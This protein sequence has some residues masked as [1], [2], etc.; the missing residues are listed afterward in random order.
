[1]SRKA[2]ASA[3]IDAADPEAG[4]SALLAEVRAC[5]LCAAELPLGPRPVLRAH[6]AARLL[7]VGQ[8]P[9]T[10]VHESGIP[11]ND[12]SGRRLRD[13]L[14][15]DRGTFYDERR[16]AIVPMGFCYPGREERGGDKPPRPECAPAWHP[17]LQ[18]ALPKV[19]LTLL[20]GLYAQARYLGERRKANLTETVRA[21]PDYLP[22][23]LPLPH[24]SWRNTAWLK[25]NPWFETELLPA[26]RARV[27]ALIQRRSGRP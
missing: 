23:Y 24:P 27:R 19:E 25:R 9:G 20:V 14:Q 15:T 18:A 1:M 10:K 17:R 3:S 22:A 7:I 11:W 12:N 8:A 26:L 2:T 6:P 13:W 21:W 5:R 16:V 4:L